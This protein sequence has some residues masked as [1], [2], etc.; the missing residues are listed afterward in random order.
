MF[1]RNRGIRLP[2]ECE[3][4]QRAES[5]IQHDGLHAPIAVIGGQQDLQF[6]NYR[7]TIAVLLGRA[8]FLLEFT[9][10]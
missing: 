3:P 10:L 8:R 5:D 2:S 7:S 6:Q 4:D 9:V 1:P